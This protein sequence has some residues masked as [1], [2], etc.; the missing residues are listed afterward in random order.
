MSQSWTRS[1]D[2]V[3]ATLQDVVAI[4]S[5]NPDLPG[6]SRGEVGMVEYISDFF[7]AAGIPY[8]T[9]EILPGRSNIVATL[10]GENLDC[11]LL[12]ECHMDTASADIMTIPPFEPHI[13]D[14]LLYGRGACDT[15]AGG[16]A[17]MFAMKRLKTAGIKPPCTIKYAGAVDEEYRFRGALHLA[18]TIKADAAIIAEPTELAVIR[19]HKGIARFR[20]V[21]KGIAAHSSKPHLGINAI[22]KMAR[23]I[24]AIENEIVPTYKASAHPL[25]GSPTANIGVI[26]GGTQFNFV[27]DRCVIEIDRR[28][29][30]G[31]TPEGALEEFR[32]LLL[33]VQAADPE[34]DVFLEEPFLL[35]GAMETPEDAPI[36]QVAADACR[37]VQ[38]TATITGVPYGTDASKFTAVGVPAI[39]FGPGSINQAHAAVEWIACEQVLTAVDIYQQMMISDFCG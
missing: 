31:Q 30:P 8:G 32:E 9:Q 37:T 38:G 29:I 28:V 19:A 7:G 13:R 27:P 12:F 25:V 14:G 34:L 1:E 2:E 26:S 39:V 22:S 15:K 17:M 20:I 10:E 3:L 35:D 21:V 23:L 5:V 18:A 36:I 33:R 11:V 4:E 24:C 6:G 16:V